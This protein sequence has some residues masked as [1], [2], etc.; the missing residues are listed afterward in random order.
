MKRKRQQSPP[1]TRK[2]PEIIEVDCEDS[3]PQNEKN[4]TK[5]SWVW[6]HF[7]ENGKG[8]HAVCQVALKKS[9]CGSLLKKD[10]SGSTKNFHEHLLKVH[11]LVDPKLTNKIDKSQ[12]GIARWTQ[13]SQLVPKVVLNSDTLKTAIAYFIAE[14]DLPFSVV[15]RNSFKDLVRLL[16]E[17]VTPMMNHV[18]QKNIA[19]QLSRIY[20]QSQEKLKLGILAQQKNISFTQDA[21]TAPNVTA[22]MAVT[23]HFIDDKYC[24]VDLTIAIPHV[25]G[26]HTGK[27]FA[28]L[29]HGVLKEYD[30]LSKIHTITAD[31]AST[32]GKMA[33]ELQLLLPSFNTD[34]QLLGCIA[35][36]INLG[37]KAGL[38]VLGTL[39]NNNGKEISMAEMDSFESSLV[40]SIL[41]LTLVPDGIGLDL[42]TV[43]KQIHGLCTYVRFSPQRRERFHAVVDFA[44]P[45]LCETGAKFTCLD[46][47]V[48]TQWNS[49]FHMFQRA[50]QLRPS[51][52]HFC[53]ENSEVH[54]FK[55]SSSEWDQASNIMNLLQ[56]L[57]EATEMLCASKYLSL[58]LALPVYMVLMKQLKRVQRGLYDQAQLIQPATQIIEKI[59]QYLRN[60]L[61][62][63]IY[64][65]SMIL[66]PTIKTRFWKKYEA[67]IIEYYNLSVDNISVT[68][69][70][71]ADKFKDQ[72]NKNNQPT[73]TGSTSQSS[74]APAMTENP[75]TISSEIR[76]AP[77]EPEKLDTVKAEIRQYLTEAP[78][79]DG[80]DILNYWFT[81][82]ARFPTLAKMARTFLAIP[83]TS[84][85]SERV[86]SKG[87]RIIS[88]QRSSLN[89]KSVEELLC[90]KEW[91]QLPNSPL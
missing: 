47:D 43:L 6:T 84:A 33:R 85:A 9:L 72:N 54:K 65:T 28:D 73:P 31:N 17:H 37:A 78:E 55:L 82:R 3:T 91:Y 58:N 15:E 18:S 56:P 36:V 35:H 76:D 25:Q 48:S 41:N 81:R 57:S 11:R 62:K 53:R 64:I 59:E 88:W 27:N 63:P 21:W 19:L 5:Q 8:N 13:T 7:K 38:A 71:M 40:M 89:P 32:N 86:F 16:N 23:V 30:C 70:K 22:F 29:F 74:A 26:S 68:F 44:Q 66:D 50:I 69:H 90:V 52:E 79:K 12:T 87:R 51:C 77:N 80:T 49:T 14:A 2:V 60:A 46:I 4:K 1:A 83:A 34:K 75:N 10:R 45:N 39:D 67:F 24:M 61:K 20:I 42:K